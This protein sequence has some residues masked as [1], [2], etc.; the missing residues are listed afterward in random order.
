MWQCA[1]VPDGLRLRFLLYARGQP[2]QSARPVIPKT[3]A[4][5]SLRTS[6]FPTPN[7]SS[8]SSSF[9]TFCQIRPAACTYG[10]HDGRTCRLVRHRLQQPLLG[11]RVADMGDEWTR[12]IARR[13]RQ[14]C[15]W[16]RAG[17]LQSEGR[18]KRTPILGARRGRG[19]S[20]A[21]A[22]SRAAVRPSA[23]GGNPPCRKRRTGRLLLRGV[24]VG[25]RRRRCRRA[26]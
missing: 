23:P 9:H 21:Q 14:L 11:S 24:G 12:R 6:W 3:P 4:F 26:G 5:P 10:V 8:S 22:A 15:L 20:R 19:R 25:E 17:G 18:G 13:S 7:S 1:A 2:R 16:L